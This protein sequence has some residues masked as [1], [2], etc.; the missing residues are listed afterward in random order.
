MDLLVG[1][2]AEAAIDALAWEMLSKPK[3]LNQPGNDPGIM[4]DAHFGLTASCRC[5][6]SS[7]KAATT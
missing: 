2:R 6:T 5:S 4:A 3:V 1:R 7:S